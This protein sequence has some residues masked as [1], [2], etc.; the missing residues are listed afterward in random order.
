LRVAG[1]A[2]VALGLRPLGS[3]YGQSIYAVV[4]QLV[5]VTL[6][7]LA[8]TCDA[9]PQAGTSPE[10]RDDMLAISCAAIAADVRTGGDP[11]WYVA[12]PAPGSPNSS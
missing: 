9:I 8:T 1:R 4:A 6:E 11:G 5:A 12:I 2:G 10:V 7:R 3:G